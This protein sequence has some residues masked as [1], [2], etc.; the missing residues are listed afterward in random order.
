MPKYW[1]TCSEIEDSIF[2][3]LPE[4]L[5]KA[6]LILSSRYGASTSMN[7]RNTKVSTN[8]LD[9]AIISEE[10]LRALSLRMANQSKLP[11]ASAGTPSTSIT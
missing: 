11:T 2:L 4:F 3:T 1:L 7:I 9:S 8:L 6:L 5:P 10:M